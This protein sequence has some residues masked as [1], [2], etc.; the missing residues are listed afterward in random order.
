VGQSL[1]EHLV[2]G[3]TVKLLHAGDTHVDLDVGVMVTLGPARVGAT[4]RNITEPTFGSGPAA[5]TLDRHARAGFA[6]TSGKRGVIGSATLGVDA[7]VTRVQTIRGDERFVAV[8]AEAWAGKRT[9]AI[10][11]GVRKNMVGRGETL[12]TGGVSAAVRRSTFVDAYASTG[13]NARHGWGLGLRVT[14]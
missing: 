9:A 11:G 14:F 3:S 7:D 10:R 12:W 8:G 2:V 6:L 4:L 1:G 5:F 13:E